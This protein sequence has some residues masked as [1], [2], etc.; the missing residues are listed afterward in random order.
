MVTGEPN[1]KTL[2]SERQFSRERPDKTRLAAEAEEC[3]VV[4]GRRLPVVF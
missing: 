3:D 4:Q 1:K 2:A